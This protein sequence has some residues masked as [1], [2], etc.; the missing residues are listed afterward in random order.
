M[1]KGF[2][3]LEPDAV[4]GRSKRVMLTRK[5]RTAREESIRA[6]LPLLAHATDAIPRD[7]VERLLPQIEVIRAWFD[8]NRLE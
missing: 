8:Q 6:A 7:M 5:G 4:D 1:E 2:I 3:R